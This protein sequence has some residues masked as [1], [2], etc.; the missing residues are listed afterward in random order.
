M[1]D[2]N[3]EAPMTQNPCY[4]PFLLPNHFLSKHERKTVTG[5]IYWT[6]KD[7]KVFCQTYLGLDYKTLDKYQLHFF[8]Y[9]KR[10]GILFDNSGFPVWEYTEKPIMW[11]FQN[12]L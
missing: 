10:G 5:R 1:I 7:K 6:A 3:T 11:E 12:G 8:M 9:E 4:K 2:R